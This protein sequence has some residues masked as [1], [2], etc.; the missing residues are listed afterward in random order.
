LVNNQAE[1][2]VIWEI[3]VAKYG[4]NAKDFD[5]MQLARATEGLRTSI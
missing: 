2:E 4:R 3:Q 5:T 1:R